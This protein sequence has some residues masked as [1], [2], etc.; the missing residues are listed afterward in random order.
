MS[1]EPLNG[2]DDMKT[3]Y[4]FSKGVRGKHHRAYQSG[5]TVSI[6]KRDGTVEEHHYAL[7]DGAV[8]IDPDLRPRFPDSLSVNKALRQLAAH[9]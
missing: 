8:M 3:N 9:G 7:E 4:D 5:H 6:T 1:V 2:D